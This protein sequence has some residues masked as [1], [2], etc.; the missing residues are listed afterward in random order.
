MSRAK[1][2]DAPGAYELRHGSPDKVPSSRFSELGEYLEIGCPECGATL[3]VDSSLLSV[4]P[5]F[6]CAGCG[7]EIALAPDGHLRTWASGA[8]RAAGEP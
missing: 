4:S 8:L 3:C 5:E 7:R 6:E 2:F 1:V